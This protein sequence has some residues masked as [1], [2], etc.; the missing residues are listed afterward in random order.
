L[1]LMTG[2]I[3]PPDQRPEILRPFL[4]FEPTVSHLVRFSLLDVFLSHSLFESYIPP[5]WTMSIELIG[6]ALVIG[7]VAIF[8]RRS[9]RIWLYAAVTIVL[10]AFDSFYS[11]FMAGVVLAELYARGVPDTHWFR[12]TMVLGVLAGLAVPIFFGDGV[13]K[14]LGLFGIVMWSAAWIFLPQL[15]RSLES[16]VSRWLG[17]ISFPLYLVHAPLVYSLSLYVLRRTEAIALPP[18]LSNLIVVVVS[19]AAAFLAARAF[20]PVNEGAIR[21]SRWLGKAAVAW[22]V[23]VFRRSQPEPL[24]P[25]L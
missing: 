18:A 12:G 17:R 11:L 5:L 10:M 9:W 16:R 24:A 21:F 23:S 14:S 8:G 6:S 3:Y 1:M 15:R 20:T 13:P 22:W 2:L 19:V 4:S 7:L 25:I